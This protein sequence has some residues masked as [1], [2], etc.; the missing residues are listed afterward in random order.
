MARK[1]LLNPVS[2]TLHIQDG[3]DYARNNTASYMIFSSEEAVTEHT[4]GKHKWCKNCYKKKDTLSEAVNVELVET[5][6]KDYI[7]DL[8]Q[9]EKYKKFENFFFKLSLVT[10]AVSL[11]FAILVSVIW[12]LIIGAV[13]F[14]VFSLIGSYMDDDVNWAKTVEARKKAITKGRLYSA[15]SVFIVGAVFVVALMISNIDW[16]GSNSNKFDDVFNKDPNTW[17]DEEEDYVNDFFDWL[18]KQD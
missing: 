5:D 4:K 13:S 15:L 10:I 18:D 1:Y 11:L 6:L 2:K 12:G 8:P 17:T 7:G 16:F 14:F 3:C 9:K